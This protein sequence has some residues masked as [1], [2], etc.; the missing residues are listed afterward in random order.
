MNADTTA[1]MSFRQEQFWVAEQLNPDH[2]LYTESIAVRLYG[3]LNPAALER[4]LSELV[5]RHEALR[6]VFPFVDGAPVQ[7]VLPTVADV[8][9]LGPDP[10]DPG[11]E[12]TEVAEGTE[13]AE[14]RVL[15]LARD[16]VERPQD[17]SAG[18]L[19]R[20]LLLRVADEDHALVLALHHLTGD[21][22][23]GRIL[24]AELEQLYTA[25]DAGD[26]SPLVPLELR[27]AD[28]TRWERSLLGSGHL[29]DDIAYWRHT[30]TGARTV[31]ELPSALAR[32]P[33][34]GVRGRR[35]KFVLGDRLGDRLRETA[36][37]LGATPYMTS[38]AA[39][40]AVMSR[41]TGER[42]LSLGMLVANR[43]P[44]LAGVVGLISNTV[45]VRLD[46][47]GD[48]DLGELL[49]RCGM[50]CL[51]AVDHGQ[52]ALEKVIES[53][54]PPRDPSRNALIQ[55]LFLP[56]ERAAATSVWG[57][58][59]VVPFE[60]PRGRGRLDTIVESET[61]REEVSVWVEYDTGILDDGSVASVMS[62]YGRVL[63]EWTRDPALRLSELAPPPGATPGRSGTPV[64]AP[65]RTTGA[66]EPVE[67]V[68]EILLAAI[69][70]LW[71]AVLEVPR[72]EPGDDF[73]RSGGHSM[74]SA[75]F[76]ERIHTTLGVKVPIRTV[77]EH[78][79]LA[80][81]TAEVSRLHPGLSRRLREL[82]ALSD[83]EFTGLVDE[84]DLAAA[85]SPGLAAA[86]GPAPSEASFLAPL[87]H[88]QLQLWLMEQLR[89]GRLTHT[90]PLVVS[91]HGP[92]DVAALR[93]AVNEVVARHETLRT[94]FVEVGGE[95]MQ[96]VAGELTLPV[97]LTDLSALPGPERDTAVEQFRRDAGYHVFDLTE[98]PLL[99]A[100]VARI[101]ATEHLVALVF[102]HLLTDEVSMTVFMR[103]LSEVYGARLEGRPHRLPALPFPFSRYVAWERE[104]L[105]GPEGDRLTG[106][107]RRTLSGAAELELPVDHPRP[108]TLTFEGDYLYEPAS[109]RTLTELTAVAREER[110][111]AFMAYVAAVVALLHRLSGQDDIVIGVPCENRG[112]PRSEQ[113][114]GC[115]LN[116]VP[117]RVD[118]S[119]DPT[120]RRLVRRVRDALLE[121]YEHQTLPMSKIVEAV[122]PARRPNRLPLFTIACELQLSGWFPLDLPG[123][124]IGYDFVSH[125]TSRYEMSFHALSQEDRMQLGL[126]M[127]T[128]LW[129][130]ETGM[131][132]LVELR[133]L[134]EEVTADPGRRISTCSG[135]LDMSV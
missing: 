113:L 73:F 106:F 34:K 18:P 128:A 63:G 67:P 38:L 71:E 80:E 76:T 134:L 56:K 25:F 66:G 43:R 83:E 102:H 81:F 133:T 8:L 20:A 59:R 87:S 45:P 85:S 86:P 7:R 79:T 62:D 109:A 130:R 89:P 32:P 9:T 131:R 35:E 115:F 29:D 135:G 78:S 111:T 37:R 58:L 70:H 51:E 84:E 53:V 104:H 24:M 91:V 74:L 26:P 122:R 21:V 19:F 46:L 48:P 27:Y 12:G 23:S 110:A 123:C 17:L 101:T 97:P 90:V 103:E 72:A 116:A 94:T 44:E 16:F 108:D 121:A 126:E 129:R 117:L 120:F 22:E 132:R 98:G 93:D 119:G 107:W 41:A 60:V 1:P 99:L 36:R 114:I 75:W 57:A 61:D 69:A 112:M 55:H 5:H 10:A 49:R 100:R 31:L 82:G 68:D 105:S 15:A 92:L 54:R 6:T 96:R 50:R 124:R 4:A 125:E 77:F 13:G 47:S 40:A 14:Q 64:A 118:C 30:L 3:P 42:D 52:I 33:V 127:N 11:A 28:Y 95:P 88:S 39:Y 2:A 65:L